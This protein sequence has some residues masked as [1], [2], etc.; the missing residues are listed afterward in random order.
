[1]S[2]P[3]KPYQVAGALLAAGAVMGISLHGTDTVLVDTVDVHH[4]RRLVAV[5]AAE[6]D[7]HLWEVAPLDDDL[8]SVFRYLVG[9]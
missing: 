1:M 6:Q 8:D 9:R 7:A 4:F 2:A 5:T 3:D